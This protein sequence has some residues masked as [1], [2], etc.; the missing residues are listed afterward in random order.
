M[1]LGEIYAKTEQGARELK[2]RKLSLPISL[3]SLLIMIDGNRTIGE[4][5]DGAKALRVDVSAVM[6]LERAGLIAKRFDA[7]SSNKAAV[8]T[9]A[10]SEGDVQR[11]L[12]AQQWMSN[13]ISDHLGFRGYLMMMRLQRAA[14]LRDLHDLLPDFSQALV[15]RV[16]PAVAAPVINELNRRIVGDT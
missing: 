3:R 15:K 4:V 12:D 1:N 7:P 5:L 11:F 8:Q 2:E 13:A 6:E 16:G 9:E 10:R 14:N